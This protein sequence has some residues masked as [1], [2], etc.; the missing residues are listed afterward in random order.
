MILFIRF[1]DYEKDLET[2]GI[3][4]GDISKL[5]DQLAEFRDYMDNA[6]TLAYSFGIMFD[7]L[8]ATE[9]SYGTDEAHYN[10]QVLYVDDINK[11]CELCHYDHREKSVTK[12]WLSVLREI[13]E[14][15]DTLENR[16]GQEYT[17]KFLRSLLVYFAQ[18]DIVTEL[19]K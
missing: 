1:D 12:A 6:C 18:F 10:G 3:C 15:I 11:F 16:Y 17:G 19:R 5:L 13:S 8:S 9:I 2:L 14:D 7:L 4:K